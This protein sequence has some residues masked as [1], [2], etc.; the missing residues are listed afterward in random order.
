M[1]VSVSGFLHDEYFL[2]QDENKPSQGGQTFK[3]SEMRVWGIPSR[4]WPLITC[5]PYG[6]RLGQNLSPGGVLR[7]D[8]RSHVTPNNILVFGLSSEAWCALNC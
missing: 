1:I 3:S 2:L 4:R 8:L 7:C 6:L 5:F